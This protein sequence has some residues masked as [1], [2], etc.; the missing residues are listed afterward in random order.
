MSKFRKAKEMRVRKKQAKEKRKRIREIDDDFIYK[1]GAIGGQQVHPDYIRK[2]DGFETIIYVYEY[3]KN[4][5]AG[6]MNRFKQQGVLIVITP[7]PESNAVV[8]GNINMSMSEH[9]GRAYDPKIDIVDKVK[10]RKQYQELEN[11]VEDI[12]AAGEIVVKCAIRLHL[13]EKT[14]EGLDKKVKETLEKL[15]GYAIKGV[16]LLNEQENEQRAVFRKSTRDIL[17]GRHGVA[18]PALTFAAGFPFSFS[19]LNDP[20]G[21]PLGY[22]DDGGNFLIDLFYRTQTRGNYN[23]CVFGAQRSGKSTLLKKLLK[24]WEIM[25]HRTRVLDPVGEFVDIA[26]TFKGKVINLDGSGDEAINPL[27]FSVDIETSLSKGKIFLKYIA[28]VLSDHETS[29]FAGYLKRLYEN[30]LHNPLFSDVRNEITE[31]LKLN[32]LSTVKRQYL[33][34]LE[35]QLSEIVHV[36]GKYFNRKS[37]I[38]TLNEDMVVYTLRNLMSQADNVKQAQMF[39]IKSTLWNELITLGKIEKERYESGVDIKDIR[40]FAI[41]GDEMHHLLKSNNS[42]GIDYLATIQREAPKYFGG[43]TIATHQLSDTI[44]GIKSEHAEKVKSLFQLSQYKFLLK[45]DA[46]E[47]DSIGE[48]FKNQITVREM[49]AIPSFRTGQVLVHISGDS[50]YKV[51][52][53]AS[54]AELAL[55]K[56]GK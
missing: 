12:D 51:N 22:T 38:N 5:P 20:R 25:G 46:N 7:T 55:F 27:D 50:N 16:V 42:D 28:P 2:G 52:I 13:F 47:L 21:M 19:Q 30:K 40:C 41:I 17:Y 8:M 11:L 9:L 39:N 34:N 36:Y 56:G 35:I 53:H 43:L 18:M 37:T 24:F 33:E 45:L 23:T 29:L 3:P 54:E 4:V 49:E 26:Y 1:V 15:E 6:W 14:L 32:I 44:S 48:V 31:E 10:S